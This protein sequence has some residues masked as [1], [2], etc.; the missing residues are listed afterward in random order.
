MITDTLC[1][2]WMLNTKSQLTADYPDLSRV[3]WE[4]ADPLHA[5]FCNL[6]P[7]WLL[8][9]YLYPQWWSTWLIVVSR[10]LFTDNLYPDDLN[11]TGDSVVC[12][13]L[14]FWPLGD[15][16]CPRCF[17]ITCILVACW[18]SV[19]AI[20]MFVDHRYCS[21]SRWRL[22][23]VDKRMVLEYTHGLFIT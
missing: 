19:L 10:I 5:L 12:S 22:H 6:Y 13:P 8:V 21:V 11:T 16:I 9:D 18:S 14:V 20:W 3:S 2:G 4:I 1:P 17:L 7:I 23:K 15:T